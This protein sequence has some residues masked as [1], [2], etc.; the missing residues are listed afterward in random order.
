MK[1]K[2][3]IIVSRMHYDNMKIN[4]IIRAGV[5]RDKD[6]TLMLN[7]TKLRQRS[8]SRL[9][10]WWRNPYAKRA[11]ACSINKFRIL[12]MLLIEIA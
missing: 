8:Q 11:Y 7:M 10:V 6:V 2:R 1:L 5:L 4:F 3:R 9:G 12:E